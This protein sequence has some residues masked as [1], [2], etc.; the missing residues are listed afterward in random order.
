MLLK[1]TGLGHIEEIDLNVFKKTVIP[2][3]IKISN[4]EEILQGFDIEKKKLSWNEHSKLHLGLSCTNP[5][6]DIKSFQY[7]L[8]LTQLSELINNFTDIK[9]FSQHLK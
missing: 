7:N 5:E 8:C 3:E 2:R 9:Y 6:L 4:F 1:F